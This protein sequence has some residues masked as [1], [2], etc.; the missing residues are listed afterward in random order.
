MDDGGGDQREARNPEEW[1][2]I[3]KEPGVPVDLVRMGENLEVSHQVADHKPD[4]DQPGNG[5]QEFAADRGTKKITEKA[6]RWSVKGGMGGQN[7]R[8]KTSR[9]YLVRN[10]D[11]QLPLLM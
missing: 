10:V 2:E 11:N 1:T 7:K 5:H 3:M 8:A 9:A 6:H 4:K